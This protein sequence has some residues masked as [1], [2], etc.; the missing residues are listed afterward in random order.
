MK[1]PAP[2]SRPRLICRVVRHF[3]A[4]PPPAESWAHRHVEGCS[5][6]AGF[7]QTLTVVDQSLATGG[8][9]LPDSIPA[10]LE[11]RIWAAV[12]SDRAVQAGSAPRQQPAWIARWA[13]ALAAVAVIVMAG[14]WFAPSSNSD[15]SATAV[16]AEFDQ[17][18]LQQMV[19]Q[20][21]TFS[22]KWLVLAEPEPGPPVDN[23]LTEEWGALEADASAAL[24]FLRQS[25]IP[26]R[27]TAS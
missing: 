18:D 2:D 14:L 3:Y 13:G 9:G 5:V 4:D 6:C 21:E 20:L 24:E 27:S 7:Y 25:F 26:S 17:Q 16:A 23:Q 8:P 10:G 11:D 19:S 1:P 12:E 15:P 22:E